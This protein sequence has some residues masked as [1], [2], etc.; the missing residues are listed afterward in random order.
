M[1]FHMGKFQDEMEKLTNAVLKIS[2]EASSGDKNQFL[3][4]ENKRL[5]KENKQMKELLSQAKEFKK[6][7]RKCVAV[8]CYLGMSG[9]ATEHQETKAYEMFLEGEKLLSKGGKDD[10]ISSQGHR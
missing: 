8:F 9:Y 7:V 2:E 1:S 10:N 6:Y 4:S 5:E 3:K